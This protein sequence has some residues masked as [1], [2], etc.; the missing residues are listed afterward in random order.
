MKGRAWLIAEAGVNHNGDPQRALAMIDAAAEA[1]AD[2][3]KFQTFDPAALVTADAPQA[4][5]QRRNTGGHGGQRAL[6]ERLTLSRE[7]HWRLREHC[8]RRGIAFLSSPFDPASARFLIEDMQLPRLKL[9]SGELTNA[10]LLWQIARAGRALILSTGM[11]DLDEVRDALAVLAHG[12]LRREPPRDLGECRRLLDEA[13][14]WDALRQRVTLLHCT[15]EYPCPPEAVNLRALDRLREA[16]ALPVGYSDHT[17]GIDIALWA[18]ARGATVIEKHFTLDRALPGPDHA[19]S[20]EP[21]ELGALAAGLRRV[22]C[23]LG[24]GEKRPQPAEAGNRRIARKSLVALRPIAAGEPF[25]AENLGTKRPAGGRSPFDYW[26]LLGTP[27]DRT[28]AA[29]EVIE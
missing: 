1:G 26:T 29:D 3:V 23:V 20:L 15:T 14:A 13:P 5:Y 21:D 12:Y 19:A 22:E 8:E 18:A 11:A 28:Y 27:A 2:A 6:L 17:E 24:D 4:E 10:P 7:T 9:G 16:F 25:T